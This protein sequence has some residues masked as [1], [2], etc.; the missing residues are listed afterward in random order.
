MQ[1]LH[2][3]WAKMGFPLDECHQPYALMKPKFLRQLKE[4]MAEYALVRCVYL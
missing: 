2:E 4:K 3:L 1:K